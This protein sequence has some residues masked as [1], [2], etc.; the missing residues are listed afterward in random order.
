MAYQTGTASSQQDLLDKLQTF[1]AANGWTVDNW[2]TGNKKLS[3]HKS[4]VYVHFRW[5]SVASTGSIGLYHSLGFVAAGTNPWQHTDDSGSG[6]TTATGAVTSQRRIDRIGDGPFTTYYFFED[7]TYIHMVLEYAPGLYRHCYFGIMTKLGTWT[8]GEYMGGT[9]WYMGSGVGDFP[10]D[11]RHALPFGAG[12]TQ[13]S[14]DNMT[15]HAEGMPGEPSA[16]TKWGVSWGGT[17]AGNDRAAVG[18]LNMF[19]GLRDGPLTNAFAWIPAN[20]N[21]GYIPLVPIPIYLRD[22]AGLS[23]EKWHLLGYAPDVRVCNIRHLE[24]AEEKTIG[25]DTWTFFPWVRKRYELDD[26]E[27]SWYGGIAL[28]KVTT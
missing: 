14:T 18:R 19:G 8:G 5:D 9:I 13:N 7:D 3:M 10:Q 4:T 6:Y 16:S 28:K 11:T 27:E 15:I 12:H 24:P 22:D 25:S 21:N 26:A 2:D 23:P 17:I 1:A 20:P